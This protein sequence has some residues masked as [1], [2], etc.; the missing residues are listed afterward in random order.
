VSWER[1]LDLVAGELARVRRDHGSRAIYAGSYGWASAGRFHHAQSQVHRFLNVT[2]GYTRSVNTYSF[3]AAEVIVPH[4]TGHRFH[5]VIG[6]LTS[7]PVIARHT[8]LFVGFGGVPLKNAQVESGGHGRHTVRGWLDV[9]RE[10]GVRFVNIGPL[11]DDL[12][13]SVGAEWLAPRP[14]T[15]AAIML[16]LMHTLVAEGLHDRAFLARYCVGFERLRAYLTGETDGRPK[17]A[18]WAGAIADL[19]PERLR[20]LAREMAAKR[21]MLS[22]SWSAQRTDH[23]EQPYWAAIALAAMLGQI[24]LPGGGFGLGYLLVQTYP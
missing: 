7:W 5:E 10:G 4:V 21:T 22:V 19:D 6:E 16:G 1:A 14:G 24:G 17:D 3:A 12:V 8:E 15:D 9:C 18:A 13:D 20:S 11:R 23:G 2:G